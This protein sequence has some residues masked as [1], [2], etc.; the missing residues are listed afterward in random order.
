MSKKSIIAEEPKAPVFQDQVEEGLELLNGRMARILAQEE[1]IPEMEAKAEAAVAEIR[2]LQEDLGL[3]IERFTAELE[4]A[5]LAKL[6]A[7]RRGAALKDQIQKDRQKLLD[8]ANELRGVYISTAR[9]AFNETLTGAAERL[10]AEEYQHVPQGHHR[11]L[12]N[13]VI[14]FVA[15]SSRF[16]ELNRLLD[17]RTLISTPRGTPDRVE[18]V[19]ERMASREWPPIARFLDLGRIHFALLCESAA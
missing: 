17:S 10:I 9:K 8:D 3:P 4:K 19:L 15:E 18:Q 12:R 5:E 6:A 14:E 2:R 13:Q 7:E 11:E 16:V 1:L